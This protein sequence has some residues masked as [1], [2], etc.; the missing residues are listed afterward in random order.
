MTSSRHIDA[1]RQLLVARAAGIPVAPLTEQYPDFDV[2]DAYQVQRHQLDQWS[3]QGHAVVGHKIGLTAPAM[4]QQLGVDQ[5]D[6]GVLVDDMAHA[7]GAEIDTAGLISPRVEPEIAFVL[8]TALEGPGVT[9]SAALAAVDHVSA[10]LEIID[11]RIAD[12]RIRLVDTIAD[13][14]S[15][16]A[17]VV[18]PHG[19]PV[20]AVDLGDVACVLDKN[21]AVVEKGTSAAVLGSPLNA[22]VWLANELGSR[23]VPLEGGHVVL[24]GSITAAVAVHPGDTVSATLTGIGS[25]T[26]RFT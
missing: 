10:A 12:W 7:G 6:Y 11:S 9:A 16:G 15:S 14:A 17:Y 21:G 13:D 26:A 19:V 8:A 23:G 1:A 22:L 24:S 25:V 5:P 4:Q 2:D 20:G 3:A 18:E